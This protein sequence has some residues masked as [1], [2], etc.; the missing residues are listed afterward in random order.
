MGLFWFY[1]YIFYFIKIYKIV[2]SKNQN[3]DGHSANLTHIHFHIIY[4]VDD[5]SLFDIFHWLRTIVVVLDCSALSNFWM[6]DKSVHCWNQ[7]L[8]MYNLVLVDQF[9]LVVVDRV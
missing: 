8:L 7:P 5:G 9:D 2:N 6:L 1:F 4:F 3:E